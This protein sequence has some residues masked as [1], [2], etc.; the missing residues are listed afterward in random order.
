MHEEALFRDLRRQLDE[1]ARRERA[2]RVRR[3]AIW[4]GALSHVRERTLRERWA[5]L[6][7]GSAAEGARLEVEVS[8]D[9]NDPR[10]ADVVLREL[11]LADADGPPAQGS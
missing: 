3:V 2:A 5:T 4:I 6:V 7:Q 10:A 1:V 11:D 8:P 9:P